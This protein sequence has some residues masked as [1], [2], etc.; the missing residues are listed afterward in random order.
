MSAISRQLDEIEALSCIYDSNFVPIELNS[1]PFQ[2]QI[3]FQ[4]DD[5]DPE[6]PKYC[7]LLLSFT[8]GPEYLSLQQSEPPEI[9]F[10]YEEFK[11]FHSSTVANTQWVSLEHQNNI[12]AHLTHLVQS[13]EAIIYDFCEWVKSRLIFPSFDY[14]FGASGSS[15]ATTN[16]QTSL[17]AE[18]IDAQVEARQHSLR[19]TR[20]QEAKLNPGQI[21]ALLE[22]RFNMIVLPEYTIRKSTFHTFLFQLPNGRSDVQVILDILYGLKF[23]ASATHNMIV[24]QYQSADGSLVVDY[25]E[26]GED[27]A[28]TKMAMVLNLYDAPCLIVVTRIFRGL[29]LGPLRFKIIASC[30]QQILDQAGYKR[31]S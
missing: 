26:D 13:Q 27:G 19:E 22:A 21:Y 12:I 8:L 16:R 23:V 15:E 29:L 28:G 2:F 17:T 31:K 24:Y 30:T 10:F 9:S 20:V 11:I 1:P 4:E 14:K 6:N 7:P 5:F 25:D 18:Q 3:R